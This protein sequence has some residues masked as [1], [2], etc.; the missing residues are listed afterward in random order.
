MRKY[1]VLQV[2]NRANI[3]GS[4]RHVLLLLKYL[5]KNLFDPT[6]VCFSEGPLL[7]ILEKKGIKAISLKKAHSF[8]ISVIKQLYS[9]LK[10]N[11]F[12]LLHSHSGLYVPL[13][14]KFAKVP[15]IVETRHGLVIN[16]DAVNRI[17]LMKR[18]Y[19]RFKAEVSDL[20]ITVTF[21]DKKILIEKFGVP[22]NKVRKIENG[23]NIEDIPAIEIKSNQFK[24]KL[25]IESD[26]KIVGTVARFSEEKGL[27]YFIESIKHIKASIPSTKFIIVGDGALKDDL[28]SLAKHNGTFHD[29]IFTGYRK[30]AV[31]FMAI[32]DVFVLPSLSEGMPYT[33]LEAMA[34][35]VPVVATNVFGIKEL[36]ANGK[37]G[38]L[39][40]PRSSEAITEAVTHLL[41][42]PQKAKAMA[43]Q[44][45]KRVK[46]SFS[47]K[48]M[49]E[50]IEQTY[51]ELI[52]G[53]L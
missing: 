20:T 33:I 12:D 49:T 19:N 46:K 24:K 40:P 13:V 16:Y 4:E 25:Q 31:S 32:Y 29:I 36:V 1:K 14:G 7:T 3:S 38:V 22:G 48:K 51:L 30:D 23:L 39:V 34:L 21:A 50:K 5:N 35:K 2:L 18:L 45:Y 15:N 6:V 26:H 28:V 10:H 43:E 52:N 44:G 42:H 53:T 9:Y 37:T 27:E 11:K 47:A 17:G 8:D 41:T